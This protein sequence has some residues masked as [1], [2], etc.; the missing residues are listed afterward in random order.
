MTSRSRDAWASWLHGAKPA[1]MA[2]E[3]I[4]GIVV[5]ACGQLDGRAISVVMASGSVGGVGRDIQSTPCSAEHAFV[6]V[7]VIAASLWHLPDPTAGVLEPAGGQSAGLA[8]AAQAYVSS[9]VAR[10][11]VIVKNLDV[12]L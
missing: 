6:C 10:W 9:E 5:A 1:G 4:D 3:D 7:G 12:A 2:I 11:S 8:A